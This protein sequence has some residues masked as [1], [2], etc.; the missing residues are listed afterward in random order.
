MTMKLL[1]RFLLS[2]AIIGLLFSLAPSE[3]GA[4]SVAKIQ[5]TQNCCNLVPPFVLNT[6]P[7]AGGGGGVAGATTGNINGGLSAQFIPVG[8]GAGP[9]Y[10]L[11]FAQSA[12]GYSGN[13]LGVQPNLPVPAWVSISTA[14]N[15]R[16]E[17][18]VMQVG[19]QTGTRSYC[20][21]FAGNPNCTDPANGGTNN[22]RLAFSA[23]VNNFG[24]T[25]RI[26]GG[27][28]G[29]LRRTQGG[30]SV[31]R[32]GFFAAPLSQIGGPFSEYKAE[33]NTGKFYAVPNL[34]TPI[35]SETQMI[36]F[37]GIQWG[38]GMVYGAGT[39]GTG[40]FPTQSFSNTGSDA[41]VSGH[42]NISLV[43]ASMV[44]GPATNTFP[45]A[46]TLTMNVPEP[47]SIAMLGGGLAGIAL[48][49]TRGRR[50]A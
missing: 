25:M 32:V 31:Q 39:G 4:Q 17:A 6:F 21:N 43:A 5:F 27:T 38:T 13:F 30:P 50:R 46:A 1:E 23:G 14:V 34:T 37:A 10:D 41:R 3:A 22:G 20:I 49:A 2:S 44:T 40:N 12:F 33:T 11:S 8:V 18:G 48:F 35:S 16:N 36:V 45:V 9:G 29:F 15:F 26:L 28:P 47:G 42:G 24:G 7:F 19:G